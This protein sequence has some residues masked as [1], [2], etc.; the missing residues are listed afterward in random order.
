[1]WNKMRS[2]SPLLSL[3]ASLGVRSIVVVYVTFAPY[4]CCLGCYGSVYCR[5]T[6]HCSNDPSLLE[7]GQENQDCG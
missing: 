2:K 5:R 6:Q 4:N 7:L 1:M 3:R